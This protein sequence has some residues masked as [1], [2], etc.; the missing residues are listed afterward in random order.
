M[1]DDKDHGAPQEPLQ[2]NEE[3]LK[4]RRQRNLALA[5]VLGALVTLFFIVTI[6]K[7]GGNVAKRPVYGAIDGV[8][9][10]G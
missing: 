4:R 5:W 6:A 9:Q 2:W 7:L 10:V 1:T 8:E 3:Q